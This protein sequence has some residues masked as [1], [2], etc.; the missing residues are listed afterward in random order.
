MTTR[1]HVQEI[2]SPI[3]NQKKRGKRSMLKDLME[4]KIN[5]RHIYEIGQMKK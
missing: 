4:L 3:D 5:K 2:Y 1:P